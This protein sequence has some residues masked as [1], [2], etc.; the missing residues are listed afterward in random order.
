MG[1]VQITLLNGTPLASPGNRGSAPP[2]SSGPC[3]L[4]RVERKTGHRTPEEGHV[5][6]S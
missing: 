2:P 6:Q 3:R 4:T 5:P 1:S